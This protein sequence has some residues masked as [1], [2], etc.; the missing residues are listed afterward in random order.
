MAKERGSAIIAMALLLFFLLHSETTHAATFKVG[1]DDGWRFGVSDWPNGKSFKAGDIL[2][3]V[4]NR[5]NHNV[6]VVD[7]DGHDSCTVPDNA[8]VFQTGDDK[9]TLEKGEN[10]F[11]CGF[12][13][14]C[15]NGMNLAI[16]AA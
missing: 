4:Y 12:T 14:H 7:K 10:Y 9:I 15:A 11:I 8:T 5:A 2:E 16:T 6:A 1:D 13:G 3:F